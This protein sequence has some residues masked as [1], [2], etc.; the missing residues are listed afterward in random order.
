MKM[1]IHKEDGFII[2][3]TSDFEEVAKDW[4]N[5]N[6]TYTLTVAYFTEGLNRNF[7]LTEDELNDNYRIINNIM[8]YDK[9]RQKNIVISLVYIK[10]FKKNY[11]IDEIL[12]GYLYRLEGNDGMIYYTDKI[13]KYDVDE[14]I[15]EHRGSAK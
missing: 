14:W 10:A 12:E 4:N 11:P 2:R 13:K 15:S 1:Y 9:M 5:D 7:T 3:K 8:L 6:D